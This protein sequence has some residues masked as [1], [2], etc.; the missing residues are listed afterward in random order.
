MDDVDVESDSD[1]LTNPLGLTY[2]INHLYL[3]REL[4]SKDDEVFCMNADI[5][6]LFSKGLQQ[7]NEL[8][9]E[10]ERKPTVGT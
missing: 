9:L 10:N 1:Q 8:L 4:P 2:L 5:L 6:R 3:P 7:L